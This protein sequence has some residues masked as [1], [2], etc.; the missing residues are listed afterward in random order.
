MQVESQ[1]LGLLHAMLVYQGYQGEI[2]SLTYLLMQSVTQHWHS[3]LP[4]HRVPEAVELA[5]LFSH[6]RLAYHLPI[7]IAMMPKLDTISSC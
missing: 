5:H 1:L 3:H 7:L 6:G 4:W 2:A